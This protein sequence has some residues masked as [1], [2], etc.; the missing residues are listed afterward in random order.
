MST[1]ETAGSW[2][3]TPYGKLLARAEG[4]GKPRLSV[5]ETMQRLMADR[6]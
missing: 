6:H 5:A 3:S 2:Y 1:T 4:R